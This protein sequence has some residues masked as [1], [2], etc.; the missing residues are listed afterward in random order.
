MISLSPR[1][2]FT[3]L[4]RYKQSRPLAYRIFIKLLSL[5]L[6]LA[7]LSTSIQVYNEYRRERLAMQQQTDYI[8]SSHIEGIRKGLWDLDSEQLLLQLKGIMNFSNVNA[9]TLHS[10]DWPED[11]VVGTPPSRLDEDYG[12][13]FDIY[14]IDQNGNTTDRLLGELTVYHDMAAIQSKLLRSAFEIALFQSLLVLING[15]VLLLIVHFM[16]T[17]HLE[18]MARYTRSIGAGNLTQKLVLPFKG[19][20]KEE[21]EIDAVVNAMNDMRAAILEDIKQKDQIEAELRYHRDQ[22][23]EQVRR[24]T[25]RLQDAKESAE[26]ANHA[27]SQFL[28]TM[29]HEIKTPLNGILGMVELLQR[30]PLAQH[31]LNKLAA[32]YQSG[33]ALLEILNGLL[34]YAR[35]E[36]G[37]YN[38]E[39]TSFHVGELVNS[40]VLLFSAQ[41]QERHTELKVTISPDIPLQCTGG[42]GAIRQILSNLVSNAI[43]FTQSGT[44]TINVQPSNENAELAEGLLFEVEDT[45]IGIPDAY[46]H[47]IFER[48]SQADD[49]ITRRFGG[50]GLGLAIT[51]QLVHV[52]GGEIG[53]ESEEGHGSVFWFFVPIRAHSDSPTTVLPT[54]AANVALAPMSVLLVEDTPI[55]QAVTTELLELDGHRV[56]LAPDGQTALDIATQ[57]PFDLILMDIHLPT[58]S[59]LEVARQ[60]RNSTC[61]NTTTPIVALTAN[62][63][64]D[65]V[66]RCHDVGIRVVIPK[67]FKQDV[68]YQ[69][70]A[71]QLSEAP[72]VSPQFES[73]NDDLL[74]DSLLQ[75]HITA[76]GPQR[77][78]HLWQRFTDALD[79]GLQDLADA[80]QHEDGY[81]VAD[82]AHRLAGDAD[83]IGAQG[84]ANLLR[85]IEQQPKQG[86]QQSAEELARLQECYGQTKQR[87]ESAY[88]P[89]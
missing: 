22:L 79:E 15:L 4:I 26:Q 8:T 10:Q 23:Q 40:T 58:L 86:N 55:N 11:I 13:T 9:V 56:T 60:L 45:G 33:E 12:T 78:Q 38:P 6:V 73:A 65:N 7:F 16:I 24:R 21:D 27:K 67:P 39:M 89:S 68:L 88:N 71:Q 43:K 66:K 61:P 83:A 29:S 3:S 62:V 20:R 25:Q 14:Y 28:A 41:A 37:R 5:S 17:R 52:L 63:Q 75:A 50:T 57:Q 34:D 82:I 19:K 53:V 35:L 76:L 81:E 42:A 18:Y 36:E 2:W 69:V 59:G 84:L 87:W 47:R 49:S 54:P 51:A 30:E 32:I 31:N 77:L 80:Y 74:N 85:E 48:F 1:H 64:P 72:T 46:L 44:V 70:M